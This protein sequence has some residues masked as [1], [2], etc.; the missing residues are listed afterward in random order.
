[1]R[2]VQWLGWAELREKAV[3]LSPSLQRNVCQ[4]S[5]VQLSSNKFQER[6]K[7]CCTRWMARPPMQGPLQSKAPSPPIATPRTG[8]NTANFNEDEFVKIREDRDKTLNM[9]QLIIPSIQV[10]MRAGN[11]PPPEDNGSVY[12]KVPINNIK[13]L[14]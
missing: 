5:L 14:I 8:P 6:S 12:I 2:C 7:R 3:S 9:P 13:N 1:M 10:N 11:L 4:D